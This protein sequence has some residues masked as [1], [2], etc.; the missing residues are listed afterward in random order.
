M[1]Q[2]VVSKWYWFNHLQKYTLLGSVACSRSDMLRRGGRQW[3]QTLTLVSTLSFIELSG[4]ETRSETLTDFPGTSLLDVILTTCQRCHSICVWKTS[5]YETGGWGGVEQR[6]AV[7]PIHS[8]WEV[9]N[10]GV[11]SFRHTAGA[12]AADQ[13]SGNVYI[14]W[15]CPACSCCMCKKLMRRKIQAHKQH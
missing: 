5:H 15:A 10:S 12:P 6:I 7:C 2:Q 14:N 4:C 9:S 3:W 13:R 11:Q 8:T 1:F